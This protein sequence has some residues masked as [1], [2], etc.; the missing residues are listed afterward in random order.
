VT[1]ISDNYFGYCKKEVK[2]QISYAANRMGRAEEEHSGGALVFQSSSLGE[3]FQAN[4]KRFN[5]RTFDDVVRD[6]A[7]WIHVQP[8]GYGIDTN[9][10]DLIYI[11]EAARDDLRRQTIYWKRE[12]VGQHIPLLPGKV[13]MA[14]S[15]YKVRLEKHPAAPSW[16]IIGTAGEG[17]FCHKPCT[18]SGGGKSEISKSLN[19]YMEYG[20]VFVADYAED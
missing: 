13:Y 16:R 20:S 2:T 12:G 6:N 8:E 4:S 17:T 9:Y 10:P 11:R 18:V 7:D 5:D 19:D 14:P 15:G 1:L 3:T